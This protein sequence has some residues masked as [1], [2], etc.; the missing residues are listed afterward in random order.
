MSSLPKPLPLRSW[1][2]FARKPWVNGRGKLDLPDDKR[3]ALGRYLAWLETEGLPLDSTEQGPLLRYLAALEARIVTKPAF[4]AALCHLMTALT[5]VHPGADRDWLRQW[6]RSWRLQFMPSPKEGVGDLGFAPLP[7]AKWPPET[8]ELWQTQVPS[9]WSQQKQVSY[10]AAYGRFLGYCAYR[11]RA[12]DHERATLE[13]YLAHLAARLPEK[14]HAHVCALQAA[15]AVLFPARDWSWLADHARARRPHA[16]KTPRRKPDRVLSLAFEH[17]PLDDQDR[18]LR[19]VAPPATASRLEQLRRRQRDLQA[20][21]AD[22]EGGAKPSK[23]VR[24]PPHCWSKALLASAEY[25]YGSF[26]K[27]MQDLGRADGGVTPE[28]VALWVD[29]MRGHMTTFS[30]G[31]RVHDLGFALRILRPHEDWSWLNR[32]AELLHEA[33]SPTHDKLAEIVDTSDIRKAAINRLRRIERKPKTVEA[34]LEFQD[35][36]IILLLSYRPV[37]RRNLAETR[38]GVN[39]IVDE[40]VTSGILIYERTKAGYRYE[41][42]LPQGLLPWLKTFLEVYRPILANAQSGNAAW[43]SREGKPLTPK[44]IWRRIRRATEQELGTPITLHRFR[45]CLASTVSEIAPERIEDAAQLLGHRV[46]RHGRRPERHHTPA[47]EIYRQ[48][49][50]TAAAAR[51]LAEIEERFRR[52]RRVRRAKA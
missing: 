2:D 12:V 24:K 1:P 9:E 45:D 38:L 8:N 50:G 21:P 30:A 33:G 29:A 46:S 43:L 22:R 18:W 25:A 41:V 19:A 17:W 7:L 37:R 20:L 51:R 15:L 23:R 39:L 49:S 48:R 44:R 14:G 16:S 11:S 27:T 13:G 40:N 52:P 34:A 47:I 28:A 26:L 5:R 35:G 4:Y 36:I 10:R 42:E 32:D 31:N 6:R 3:H